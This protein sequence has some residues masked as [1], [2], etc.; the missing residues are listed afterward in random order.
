MADDKSAGGGGFT[1]DI[2]D[3]EDPFN[4]DVKVTLTGVKTESKKGDDE[5]DKGAEPGKS[6]DKDDEAEG[7]GSGKDK[8]AGGVGGGDGDDL[9]DEGAGLDDR[10]RLRVSR[11]NA[12]RLKR[13][14][15][16][17]SGEL[18]KVQQEQAETQ[19]MVVN[20][21]KSSIAQNLHGAKSRLAQVRADRIAARDKDDHAR[22]TECED[23]I[24]KLTAEIAGFESQAAELEKLQAPRAGNAMVANWMAEAEDWYGKSGFE[25]E[26]A[27]A[28][29]ISAALAQQGIGKNDPRHYDEID[30]Q[31]APLL[32]KRS[33]DLGDVAEV[34]DEAEG[35]GQGGGKKQAGGQREEP[36]R[37]PAG[38]GRRQ[39]GGGGGGRGPQVP[40]ALVDSFRA[41]G[42][43]VSK[44]EVQEKM[45]R[46]YNETKAAH[47]L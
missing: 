34:D 40:K 23:E 28:Q 7:A 11:R 26:T 46:R 9:E 39:S 14:L 2:G 27:R 8:E 22:E 16:R 35:A 32:K 25:T 30:R 47:N 29:Q 17:V 3:A 43:D 13:A 1:L 18:T 45:Y 10:S 31:M 37:G 44:P 42:F 5:D 33:K 20:L 12:K 4:T 21:V 38:G 41:A 15:H 6:K 19:G 24:G 36:M